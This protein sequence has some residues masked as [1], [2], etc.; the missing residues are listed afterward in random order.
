MK[1]FALLMLSRIAFGTVTFAPATD[2]SHLMPSRTDDSSKSYYYIIGE[3]RVASTTSTYVRPINGSYPVSYAN[4]TDVA[5]ASCTSTFSGSDADNYCIAFTLERSADDAT[6][7]NVVFQI[8]AAG[9]NDAVP[10]T[11][12]SFASP[13]TGSTALSTTSDVCSGGTTCKFYV[14]M[15]DICDNLPSAATFCT[16]STP[17]TDIY[18][19]KK[20]LFTAGFTAGTSIDS[21]DTDVEEFYIVLDRTRFSSAGPSVKITSGDEKLYV[22]VSDFDSTFSTYGYDIFIRRETSYFDTVNSLVEVIP[23]SPSGSHISTFG[24]YTDDLSNEEFTDLT[25]G[26][27]KYKFKNY[28]KYRVGAY[29]LSPGYGVAPN[30]TGD[31]NATGIP[32]AVVGALTENKCFVA[33]YLFGEQHIVTRTLRYV[34]DHF[35]VYT[36]PGRAFVN[37]YNSHHRSWIDY[38]EKYAF[39][40]YFS[41]I[42]IIF[43]CGLIYVS[44]V[45]IPFYTFKLGRRIFS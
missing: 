16:T 34:R 31:G 11:I 27:N 33:T 37:F 30:D 1:I 17:S 26:S 18:T 28:K 23:A 15:K 35:L 41:K 44:P 6:R 5:S 10:I 7:Q 40:K 21:S 12:Y 3:S 8:G 14:K 36:S 2:D 39:F 25:E 4:G 19:F 22:S 38:S 13:A 32:A 20:V 43:I 9:E 45:M 42:F 29:Y 24:P